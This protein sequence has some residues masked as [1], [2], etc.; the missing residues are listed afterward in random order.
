MLRAARAGEEEA[1]L[2]FLKP[3]VHSSMFLMSNLLAH[4]LSD[5]TS[6]HGT[7]FLVTEV[8][9]DI[10]G[11]LGRT[12]NGYLMAQ[13]PQAGPDLWDGFAN[14]LVGQEIAGITGAVAQVDCA[15][16]ALG[17]PDTDYGLIR[18]EPFYHLSLKDL[19]APMGTVRGL[20]EDDVDVLIPWIRA[21]LVETG[22]EPDT[23]ATDKIATERAVQSLT[24]GNL[25]VLQ[26]GQDLVAMAG[27]NARV[28][29][30]VQIGQVYTPPQ[31]RG[32][33]LAGEAVANM[34]RVLAPTGISQSVLFAASTTA[35][36]AYEKIGFVQK[37][38]YKMALLKERQTYRGA[39]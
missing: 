39:P 24:S 30:T 20:R 17:L 18:D 37:G 1:I 3:H 8:D 12:N 22:I 7:A 31:H 11:V 4:G 29:D 35:G 28:G 6:P 34:L 13:C 32:K 10:T 21:Y 16:Q 23:S 38:Y 9:G 2:A 5:L 15:V 25:M 27:V 26:K 19:T 33:G 14:W 36:R